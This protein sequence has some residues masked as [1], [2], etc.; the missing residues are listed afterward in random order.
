MA[1]SHAAKSSSDV[2]TDIQKAFFDESVDTRIVG[3]E[4]NQRVTLRASMPLDG[5]TWESQTV[6]WADGAGVVDVASQEP[7][8]GGY[9]TADPMGPFWSMQRVS[10]ESTHAENE[11]IRDTTVTLTVETDG[12]TFG[13]TE[14]KRVFAAPGV[15]RS[16]IRENGLVAEF[17]RPAGVGPHPGVIRV[18]GSEGA[19]P[20]RKSTA[21][22]ASHGYAVLNVAYFGV[23]GLP[24]SLELIPLEYFQKAIDW[25]TARES[26]IADPL[27]AIG[28]SRGGEL[29]LLL[30]AQFPE[31]TTVIASVPSGVVFPGIPEDW[32]SGDP[33]KP[34][35]TL[36]GEP[37]ARVPYSFSNLEFL[38]QAWHMACG[39]PIET[40]PTYSGGLEETD[41]ETV[42]AATIPVENIGGPVLL[43]SG[44]DDR[45]WPSSRL[46]E[47]ALERLEDHD[48]PHPHEHLSYEEAGHAIATP[49]RPT[50]GRESAERFAFGGT[51]EAYAHA[52]A[53]SWSR[54]L[55]YLETGL[56]N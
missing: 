37:L 51:P 40:A 19:F 29:A 53:D 6:F 46:A 13:S 3:L 41:A 28:G 21:L 20:R 1:T 50:I 36:D 23:E 44:G 55:A 38:R 17:Y 32:A 7:I 16:S 12:E 47:I 45:M 33:P 4:P 5:C 18:G 34:A 35:W 11:Y 14:V 52:D 2:D 43:L 15:T 24:D 10:G 49:Y 48:Y 22:L 56:Q 30:G 25:L 9:D 54:T 27:G 8:E 39:K 42:A 31:I 26:V